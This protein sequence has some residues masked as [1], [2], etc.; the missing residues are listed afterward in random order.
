MVAY[1]WEIGVVEPVAIEDVFALDGMPVF[2][3]S[4]GV[5]KGTVMSVVLQS[6]K[7]AYPLRLI[8]NLVSSNSHQRVIGADMD[9]LRS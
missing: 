2:C 1:L 3:G 8:M 4:F 6:G 7:D 5:R 9:Q